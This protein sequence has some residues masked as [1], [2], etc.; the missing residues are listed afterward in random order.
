MNYFDVIIGSLSCELWQA[1]SFT[2]LNKTSF[3]NNDNF[4]TLNKM[5]YVP[6]LREIPV[7]FNMNHYKIKCV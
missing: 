6:K 7:Y 5:N 3:R 1:Y 2:I 4:I